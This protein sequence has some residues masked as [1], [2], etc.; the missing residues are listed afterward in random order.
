MNAVARQNAFF[1]VLFVILFQIIHERFIQI[2]ERQGFVFGDFAADV[3]VFG[4]HLV[5]RIGAVRFFADDAGGAQKNGRPSV[6][7]C[8]PLN[9]VVK[10]L[11]VIR[12]GNF[13][14][15]FKL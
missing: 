6:N 10:T 15:Y 14:F 4:K 8:S 11:N 12:L 9:F 1:F 7:V 2:A 13:L 3:G 5:L